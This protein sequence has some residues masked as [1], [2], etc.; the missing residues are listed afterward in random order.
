MSSLRPLRWRAAAALVGAGF[1]VAWVWIAG[2]TRHLI[3]IDFRW[4]GTF[5]EGAQ[6][7]VDGV[8][9]GTLQR[10]GRS[11]YSTGFEVEP[12]EH[13]IRVLRE[14]CEGTPKT[15]RIGGEDG[16]LRMLIAD[17]EEG[18]NCRVLLR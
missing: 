7:E 2:G 18:Y 11:N 6:V 10:Y 12:G 16:R 17:V 15:V 13:V 1:I 9:V 8:V 3:Q 5:L 14:D 4:G